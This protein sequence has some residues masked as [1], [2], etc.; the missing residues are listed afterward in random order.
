MNSSVDPAGAA[1]RALAWRDAVLSRRLFLG[2]G[3]ALA[4][5]RRTPAAARPRQ[6]PF[7]TFIN[8]NGGNDALNTLIPTRLLEYARVRPHIA[9]APEAGASLADGPYA[10]TDYVMHPA[11]ANIARLYREG[12][13]ACVRLVGYPATQQSHFLSQDVWSRGYRETRPL[14]SGWIARFKD[15]YAPEPTG[16][17]AL[18]L[19][20][21]LDFIGGQTRSTHTVPN[22]GGSRSINYRFEGDPLYPANEQLRHEV[23]DRILARA[24]ADAAAERARLA[25]IAAVEQA[26]RLAG[27]GGGTGG[28][29]RIEYP[30][31]AL[32]FSLSIA[33]EFVR[34]GF[35][36]SIYYS[37]C[38]D[39]DTH[40]SQ[41]GATG[42]HEGELAA[43]DE[44][45][46][47]YARDLQDAGVWSRAA[48][49]VFSEFG[50]RNADNGSGTD[51]GDGGL[52]LVMG[53]AV[54]GGMYGP[55]LRALDITVPA[56]PVRVDFR[57]VYSE[58]LADHFEVDPAPVFDE[59]YTHT[60]L[61]LFA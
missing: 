8:L 49:L 42:R 40:G 50:R 59:P 58:L 44:A 57:S 24:R 9:I 10:T 37:K 55:D 12:C 60:P 7:A 41:G 15:L 47:A 26:K 33:G 25:Q 21:Q 14:D 23:V 5:A 28:P 46:S 36:A 27:S 16:V 53:G 39:F 31:S 34:G 2:S 43:V 38:G 61:G 4:L 20:G 1:E 3:L 19:G 17:V 29:P 45:V 32:G 18:G 22:P 54:R 11:L 48:V 35:P 6:R 56:L 30:H 51:H 13:V 52:V